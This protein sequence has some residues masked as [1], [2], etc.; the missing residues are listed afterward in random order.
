MQGFNLLLYDQSPSVFLSLL[1]YDI[2]MNKLFSCRN[3]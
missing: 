1:Y 3:T 2:C